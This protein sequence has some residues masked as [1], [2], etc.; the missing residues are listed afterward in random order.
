MPS[1]GDAHGH[2]AA[3]VVQSSADGYWMDFF[4][5]HDCEAYRGHL[6]CKDER[7]R[8]WAWNGKSI[9]TSATREDALRAL[10]IEAGAR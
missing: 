4:R 8:W 1:I 9:G 3:A 6:V 7:G 5:S 2:A 10:D